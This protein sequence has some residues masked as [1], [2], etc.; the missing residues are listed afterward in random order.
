MASDVYSQ[1]KQLGEIDKQISS[2]YADYARS[3]GLSYTSLH[4]LHMVMVTESCT[5]K[6][7]IEQTF[8]P[9][10]TV[11]SAISAFCKQGIMELRESMED[12]RVKTIHLTSKGQDFAESILPQITEAEADSIA[13]FAEEERELLLKLMK[14]YADTFEKILRG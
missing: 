2:V 3:V 10:Q 4:I 7:I 13:Q 11:N 1:S 14:K 12:R 6:V 9:K 5:Q 8:L